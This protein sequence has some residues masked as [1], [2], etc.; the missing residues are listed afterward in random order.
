[1]NQEQPEPALDQVYSD[2]RLD[3]IQLTILNTLRRGHPVDQVI[4]VPRL[5]MECQANGLSPGSFSHGFVKLLLPRGEFAYVLTKEH[6]RAKASE[7][8][9]VTE[10]PEKFWQTSPIQTEGVHQ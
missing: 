7:F 5:L 6:S 3:E 4:D 8:E 1:M 2:G 9:K 10:L